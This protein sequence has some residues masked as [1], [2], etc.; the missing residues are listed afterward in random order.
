MKQHQGEMARRRVLL[1]LTFSGAGLGM[2]P[3]F[4]RSTPAKTKDLSAML[5]GEIDASGLPG[6]GAAI[7]SSRG[8]EAIGVAGKRSWPNGPPIMTADRWHIGSCT[9]ALT[10]TLAARLIERGPLRWDSTL[11]EV[12]DVEMHADWRPVKLCW[13]LCHRSGASMNFDQ[14]IWEDMVARGG[15]LTEQRRYFATEGL[16]TPPQAP[17][18]TATIYSNAGFMLAGAMMEK[19]TGRAWEDLLAQHVLK[20]LGMKDT[21]FGAPGIA[22]KLD[23]PVGHL[24]KEVGGWEPIPPAIGADNPAATGP[25]GTINLSLADWSRFVGAHL[26]GFAGRSKFL[27]KASWERLHKL[28]EPGWD[29]SPGWKIA[30]E[31]ATSK[32]VLQHIGSNGFWVAQATIYPARNRA[33]LITTNVADDSAEPVFGRVL[34]SLSE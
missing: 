16:K 28:D 31:G 10:A 4:G 25:A 17:P 9:K 11:G 22:G 5:Q 8:M 3:A 27:N 14:Q 29:Y 20:P 1:G 15:S 21:G 34:K 13:L 2:Y 12:L 24:R 6:L 23:Q 30:N 19:V 18:N 26:Q 33:V 32:P 7:V